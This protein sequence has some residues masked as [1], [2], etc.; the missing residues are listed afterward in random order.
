MREYPIYCINLEHR[1]DRK[2]HSLTQFTELGVPHEKVIYPHFTKDARGGVYGCFDSHM[3][4]WNDFLTKYPNEKY[5]LVFED[6]FVVSKKTKSIMKKSTK[7]IETNY[8]DIDIL[9]LHSSRVPT[10]NNINNEIFTNGYGCNTQSLF[11]TRHY[12]ESIITK[13]G[14]LP[15][16][17]GRHIDVELNMNILDKDNWVYTEKVFYT[18]KQYVT[19]LIDKSD[20]YSGKLDE[21]FRTDVN[22][23]A[24]NGMKLYSIIK[25]FNLL[26]DT[27]IKQIAC[28]VPKIAAKF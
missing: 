4:V 6:D 25:K 22:K 21:L 9:V 14:K 1:K 18:N 20:N 5:C 17:N 19:Q 15:E 10:Y 28:A 2:E 11:I 23:S 27:Q 12:I 7:F 16:A 13:Y 8:D 24:H 3:K 26:N